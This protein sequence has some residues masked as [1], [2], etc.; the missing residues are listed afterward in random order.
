MER[1]RQAVVGWAR[2]NSGCCPVYVAAGGGTESVS[3]AANPG[4]FAGPRA[5]SL[6][7]PGPGKVAAAPS[8]RT[9]PM[10]PANPAVPGGRPSVALGEGTIAPG[11]T[12][13]ES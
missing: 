5:L 1:L 11:A 3:T 2:P 10:S 6:P 9:A 7:A 4:I 12:L 13:V 8:P